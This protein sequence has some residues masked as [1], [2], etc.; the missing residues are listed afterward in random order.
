MVDNHQLQLSCELGKR[1]AAVVVYVIKPVHLTSNER[2]G[3]G[4]RMYINIIHK[5]IGR[6][7]YGKIS[8][9]NEF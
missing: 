4:D 5:K 9:Q 2:S 8:K 7:G 3:V 6:V 1:E